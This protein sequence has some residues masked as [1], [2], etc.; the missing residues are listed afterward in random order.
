MVVFS[1]LSAYI[2]LKLLHLPYYTPEILVL[3]FISFLGKKYGP[4]ILRIIKE[5]SA[6]LVL[7]LY[8]I[9]TLIFISLLS[10]EF[11]MKYILATAR[12]YVYIIF[13]FVIG[14]NIKTFDVKSLYFVA[15]GSVFGSFFDLMIFTDAE[16]I[17]DIYY[18]NLTAIFLAVIIPL[19]RGKFGLLMLSIA[20]VFFVALYSGLRRAF[21]VLFLALILGYFIKILSE[22]KLKFIF[23]IAMLVSLVIIFYENILN[24]IIQLIQ[25]NSYL[26]HRLVEKSSAIFLDELSIGDARRVTYIS[27][28]PDFIEKLVLPRGFLTKAPAIT[29]TGL[30]MDLPIYELL[31]TLG[32]I[33]TTILLMI[34]IWETLKKLRLSFK[35][36]LE[37]NQIIPATVILFMVFLFFDGGFLFWPYATFF[38]GLFLGLLF[39]DKVVVVFT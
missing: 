9:V 13:F 20:P 15:L 39:N 30:F 33:I 4:F 26:Y 10:N 36:S 25:G 23:S 3:F 22:R 7:Y 37:L 32:S 34:I 1:R 5:N 17:E 35:Y 24:Y 2:V 14:K 11:G 28:I 31:Y 38:T 27:E 19:V 8:L 12:G 18:V 29:G 21:I 6:V 16:N